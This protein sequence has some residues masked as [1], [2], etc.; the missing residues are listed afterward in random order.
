MRI[1][2]LLFVSAALLCTALTAPAAAAANSCLACH[3]NAQ[4]MKEL[5]F[6]HF[7]VSQQEVQAQTK[8][9]AACDQCHLGNAEAGSKEEAHKGLARLQV[10]RKKG[11]TAD[12]TTPRTY[13]LEYGTNPMNKLYVA[14]AKDGQK[15]KDASVAAI[16]WHDKT[17]DMLTQNFDTLK[18][19]CGSCHPQQF[20]EFS[21]SAMGT[22]AKQS[23]YK[24]WTDTKRGPHNCG[25]W[26]DG[27]FGV[28][29]ANTGVTMSQQSHKV[30]QKACNTCHVG[31]LDCHFNP[32]PKQ[33]K[34]L[35]VGAHTF[36]K[37]PPS[38]SCYGNGRA[39]I[40]HAGPE[41]R[42][43]GAGYYGGSFS[44]PEGNQPD[45]H[46]KA[47]VGCL[48]CHESTKSN[49]KLGHATVKRQAEASCVR[50][51]QQAVANH[52]ASLHKNLTCEACHIQQVAG[53]QA[54][55]WGP[56][57]IAGAETPFF[58]FKAYYG[59]MP[60]PI[61]IKDQKGRWIPVKP[62]PMAAMNQKE[63][64]FKPGLYW[65][66]PASLPDSQRTDDAWAYTGLHGGMV[67]NN[68]ALTWIQIDKMSHKLGKARSCDSCHGDLLNGTQVQKVT[69]D[70][71]DPGAEPFKG[72]HT[73][74]AS[75]NSLK[76]KDIQAHERVVLEKGY[77]L[78]SFA[79]WAYLDVWEV[80]GDF[81]I[82]VPRDK[83]AYTGIKNDLKQARAKKIVH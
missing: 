56:G 83:A 55:Y 75:K 39:S 79:P 61:L 54:T 77:Q 53:Y 72:S 73:V 44:F 30:N 4:K 52:A 27:N 26:F 13:P 18:K 9:P 59:I 67:G 40:C 33:P 57:K 51:H 28:M 8:M 32:Q 48:D 70:Y 43:R 46:L 74:I 82:P 35:A 11:L 34:N 7:T 19:T 23:Q 45:V 65:R 1:F 25:P 6:A 76:I 69:W 42:R 16:Q 41:D 14:T 37:T 64:P 71:S 36:S 38:L 49:P 68:K 63:S 10:V 80:A 62:F 58:K 12:I 78:S 21:T 47:K 66:F 20:E 60:E 5:G 29:Q 22:N 31:C 2:G 24:G 3:E 50:C 17:T 81:S 15:T